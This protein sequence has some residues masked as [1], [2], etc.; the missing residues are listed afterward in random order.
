M[1]TPEGQ[2]SAR[3]FCACLPD[4][5]AV[6]RKERSEDQAVIRLDS[7]KEM[8]AWLPQDVLE[9][10]SDGSMNLGNDRLRARRS[11]VSAENFEERRPAAT[12]AL[13][14]VALLNVVV[15]FEQA[16]RLHLPPQLQ[17]L[18]QLPYTATR[19][20]KTYGSRRR[21]KYRGAVSN[22]VSQVSSP[23]RDSTA[24]CIRPSIMRT[25]YLR[26]CSSRFKCEALAACSGN[27]NSCVGAERVNSSCI[28]Q[29]M[30]ATDIE[31]ST[32]DQ[33]KLLSSE[34]QARSVQRNVAKQTTSLEPAAGTRMILLSLYTQWKKNFR[35]TT[36]TAFG[37]RLAAHGENDPPGG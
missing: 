36:P 4:T 28:A 32:I 5:V 1:V 17:P 6:R 19:P 10:T 8:R 34:T 9:C 31:S 22:L 35:G 37:D 29:M 18:V 16:A 23:P 33:F 3:R 26:T 13:M 21:S 2:V 30:V 12:T 15:N 11:T 20:P 7:G 14:M 24:Q 27:W 25:Q